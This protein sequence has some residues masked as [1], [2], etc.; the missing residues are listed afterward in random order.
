MLPMSSVVIHDY[1]VTQSFT[2][3]VCAGKLEHTDIHTSLINCARGKAITQYQNATGHFDKYVEL[4]YPAVNWML[5]CKKESEVSDWLSGMAASAAFWCF[6]DRPDETKLSTS[7]TTTTQR[8]RS[9]LPDG[10]PDGIQSHYGQIGG[11]IAMM[12]ISV[13]LLLVNLCLFIHLYHSQ[14]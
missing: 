3:K 7:S 14:R 9:I 5:A 2:E 6:I 4:Y 8:G 1:I 12:V 13:V 10:L 11:W